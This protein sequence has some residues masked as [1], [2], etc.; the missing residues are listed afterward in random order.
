MGS[1]P[2]LLFSVLGQRASRRARAPT[3]AFLQSST[4]TGSVLIAV[5]DRPTQQTTSSQLQV[6]TSSS[7]PSAAPV[8]ETPASLLVHLIDESSQNDGDFV[9]R[10]RRMVDVGEELPEQ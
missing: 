7:R 1:R 6:L 9:P 4:T 10:K 8:A 5:V 2:N 3:L